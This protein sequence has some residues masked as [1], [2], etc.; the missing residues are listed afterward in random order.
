MGS[1]EAG[2]HCRWTSLPLA[3]VCLSSAARSGHPA[4]GSWR[5]APLGPPG[6]PRHGRQRLG[7]HLPPALLSPLVSQSPSTSYPDLD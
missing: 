4:G 5:S 1:E 2:P 7:P 3:G 6:A